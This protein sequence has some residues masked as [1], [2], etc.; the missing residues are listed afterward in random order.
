MKNL[1]F[2]L[3]KKKILQNFLFEQ[4]VKSND[5]RAKSNDQRAKNN[6][7]RAKSNEQKVTSNKQ[8]VTSNELRAKSNK[9]RAESFIS[10]YSGTLRMKIH[11]FK[12][13][14]CFTYFICSYIIFTFN[15]FLKAPD[16]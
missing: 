13:I 16:A 14:K 15:N 9:Q 8:K 1:L 7:Q 10:A 11:L 6:V 3:T 5:Q 4:R 2:T 12:I